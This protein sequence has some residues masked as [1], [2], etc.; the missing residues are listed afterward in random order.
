MAIPINNTTP[1]TPRIPEPSRPEYV[2]DPQNPY[3]GLYTQDK[4]TGEWFVPLPK[5]EID[6][7]TNMPVLVIEPADTVTTGGLDG[8]AV[9]FLRP[10]QIPPDPQ[11]LAAARKKDRL[12]RIREAKE[13]AEQK[14]Q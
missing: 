2:D 9:T 10:L 13:R 1:N 6:P 5:T 3:H 11:E 4:K 8:Q 7:V 12:R 14:A